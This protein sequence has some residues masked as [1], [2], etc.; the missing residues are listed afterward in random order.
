MAAF[1]TRLCLTSL[2]ALLLASTLS[3]QAQTTGAEPPTGIMLNPRAAEP[4]TEQERANIVT[5]LHVNGSVAL[6]KAMSPLL[7]AQIFNVL[8]RNY[9]QMPDETLAVVNEESLKA[10][11][12]STEAPGGLVDLYVPIY[13][14]YYSD[15]EIKQL[16]AFYSGPVGKKATAVAPILLQ[17]ARPIGQVWGARLAPM[18]LKRLQERLKLKPPPRVNQSR[19]E[20]ASP[21]KG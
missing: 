18:V 14:K 17:D 8:K 3:A 11:S 1:S 20:A 2:A 13:Y 16:I 9:P 21:R 4:I 6:A 7:A 12:E 15:E 10:I 5:L 19:T